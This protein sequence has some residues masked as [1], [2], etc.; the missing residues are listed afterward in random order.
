M[1]LLMVSYQAVSQRAELLPT[2]ARTL[3]RVYRRTSSNALR[4]RLEQ[5]QQVTSSADSDCDA[6][7]D[8]DS[9]RVM[10][11]SSVEV[12]L[13][14]LTRSKLI[15]PLACRVFKSLSTSNRMSSGS[16]EML[17]ETLDDMEDVMLDEEQASTSDAYGDLDAAYHVDLFQEHSLDVITNE[18]ADSADGDTF[19]V[20]FQNEVEFD[21]MDNFSDNTVSLV[22]SESFAN[23]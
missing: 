13:W 15:D 19:R 11:L 14:F 23:V 6:T 20:H 22:R 10:L 16:H 3:T 9:S 18:R 4:S 21:G 7:V 12:P 1:T 17:D 8:S 2:I 5:L